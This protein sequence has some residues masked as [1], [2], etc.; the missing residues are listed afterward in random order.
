MGL[1]YDAIPAFY[2]DEISKNQGKDIRNTVELELSEKGITDKATIEQEYQKRLDKIVAN[3]IKI[4]QAQYKDKIE[5]ADE[6]FSCICR[7]YGIT[8]LQL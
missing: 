6:F 8:L 3:R 5:Y 4:E 1:I 7:N 2:K